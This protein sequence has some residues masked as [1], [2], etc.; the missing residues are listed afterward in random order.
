M[1]RRAAELRRQLGIPVRAP[2]VAFVGRLTRDKGI[3]ELMEAFLQLG[4][5]FPDLRLL[6]VGCFQD[7]DP[8]PVDTR[9]CVETHPHVTSGAAVQATAPYYA[10]DDVLVLRSHREALPIV[11]LET[12]AGANPVLRPS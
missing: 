7:G 9:R 8:L 1:M 10:L 5:R 2:V 12:P 4:N 3:P 6:L 11:L